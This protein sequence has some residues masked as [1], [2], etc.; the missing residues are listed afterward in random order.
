MGNHKAPEGPRDRHL[1]EYNGCIT[2]VE[3]EGHP[4]SRSP[5]PVN[6]L[7]DLVSHNINS[8]LK[9][10]VDRELGGECMRDFSFSVSSD[11]LHVCANTFFLVR[12]LRIHSVQSVINGP[13]QLSGRGFPHI[14]YRKLVVSQLYVFWVLPN[15]SRAV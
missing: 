3:H 12:L 6:N 1:S 9:G 7:S 4:S 11:F 8:R 2:C 15:G 14:F 13:T 5:A 10:A